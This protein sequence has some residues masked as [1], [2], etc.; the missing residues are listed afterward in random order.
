MN[1]NKKVYHELEFKVV[2]E[3][4]EE[5]IF[6]ASVPELPGCYTQAKTLD[7]A[8][9]RIREVISLI[10]DTDEEAKKEKIKNPRPKSSF[11]GTEDITLH[12]A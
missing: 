9:E 1:K 4:D 12:Y 5:G 8:R 7:K 3:Q 6:I 10:L 11:F 2:I